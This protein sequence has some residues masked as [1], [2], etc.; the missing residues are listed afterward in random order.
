MEDAVTH[1][2]R[3]VNATTAKHEEDEEKIIYCLAMVGK[4]VNL[5]RKVFFRDIQKGFLFRRK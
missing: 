2:K 3:I 1:Y 4:V 5:A